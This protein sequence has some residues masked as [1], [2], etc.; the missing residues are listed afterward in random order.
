[1]S[2]FL[3][4]TVHECCKIIVLTQEKRHKERHFLQYSCGDNVVLIKASVKK[5]GNVK[6]VKLSY[7]FL[8][9][10]SVFPPV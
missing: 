7:P 1:M 4:E 9:A 5:R 10:S 2:C 3:T 6:K 8:S